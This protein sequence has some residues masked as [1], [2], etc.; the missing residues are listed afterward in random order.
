MEPTR[1]LVPSSG[2]RNSLRLSTTPGSGRESSRHPALRPGV[3]GAELYRLRCTGRH[4]DLL[5]RAPMESDAAALSA[6]GRDVQGTPTSGAWGNDVSR[7]PRNHR[8]PRSESFGAIGS[9]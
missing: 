2:L 4:D 8:R 5:V 1:N 3:V 7:T 9:D 6:C